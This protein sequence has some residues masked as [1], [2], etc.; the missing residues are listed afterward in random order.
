MQKNKYFG[1]NIV[2]FSFNRILLTDN[3]NSCSWNFLTVGAGAESNSFG[4]ATLPET[5][6]CYSTS[7][8]KMITT[9]GHWPPRRLPP[10]GL[11][12]HALV[13]T[14]CSAHRVVIAS[15]DGRLSLVL[16]T[17]PPQDGHSGGEDHHVL[18]PRGLGTDHPAVDAFLSTT[19]L[20]E[21]QVVPL[22]PAFHSLELLRE[23]SK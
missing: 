14:I 2:S 20:K 18:G 21:G 3:S 15:H 17:R 22:F 13:G 9:C 8:S 11:A 4:S 7:K 10:D 6:I 1:K 16:V 19:S 23:T 12:L 5:Y